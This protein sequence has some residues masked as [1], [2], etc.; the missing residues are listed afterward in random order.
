MYGRFKGK[1]DSLLGYVDSNYVKDLEKRRSLVGYMFM[2]NICLINL[3]ANL[4][5]VVALSNTEV[6]YT[7]AIEAIKKT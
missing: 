6:E 2:Y 3:K 5:Y 7:T 4:Q 1:C